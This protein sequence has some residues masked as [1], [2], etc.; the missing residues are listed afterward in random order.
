MNIA[1]AALSG[2]A[3]SNISTGTGVFSEIGGGVAQFRQGRANAR[4]MSD[5]GKMEAADSRREGRRIIGSQ[6]VAA[7]ASGIDPNT[8]SSLD[9][10]AQQSVENEV[11]ALRTLFAR[12]SQAAALK[13]EAASD[14][15]SGVGYGVRSFLDKGDSSGDS[16]ILRMLRSR[17]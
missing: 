16:E 4:I 15:I 6:R 5:I 13:D 8:G 14:L 1:T 12:K 10:Q 9:I 3:L 17:K 7:A 11:T 2:S